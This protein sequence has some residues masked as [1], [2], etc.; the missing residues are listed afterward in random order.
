MA[1]RSNASMPCGWPEHNSARTPRTCARREVEAAAARQ[2]EVGEQQIPRRRAGGTGRGECRFGAWDIRGEF[3]AVSRLDEHLPEDV[4]YVG[5]VLDDKDTH[6]H[7]NAG[8][9]RRLRIDAG[10]VAAEFRVSYTNGPGVDRL[11]LP[12]IPARSRKGSDGIIVPGSN[13]IIA[14]PLSRGNPG[15]PRLVSCVARDCHAAKGGSQ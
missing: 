4:A 11:T 7:A 6:G 2:D 9:R 1:R 10:G 8:F 13:A 15:A 14:R 5:M 3:D 12:C